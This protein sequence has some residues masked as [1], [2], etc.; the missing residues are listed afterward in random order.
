MNG[1][2]SAS[3]MVPFLLAPSPNEAPSAPITITADLFAAAKKSPSFP[4]DWDDAKIRGEIARYG[5][6]LT[7]ARKYPGQP[8]APTKDIDEIWHLHMMHP[9]A[10]SEDCMRLFGDILDHDGGFG[11]VPE[12]LPQLKATFNR[13]AELWKK[14]FGE[15]YVEGELDPN[16]TDCWHDCSGRC[17]HACSSRG[18]QAKLIAI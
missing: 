11:A 2:S 18:E 7:I 17:W 5:K 4:K 13:T 6:F 3:E 10:Y 14:E 8:L 12:E 9:R 1:G 16:M 15:P